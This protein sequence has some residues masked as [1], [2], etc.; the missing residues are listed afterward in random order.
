[1]AKKMR[2]ALTEEEKKHLAYLRK[3]GILI[4]LIVLLVA[5]V[6]IEVILL[7]QELVEIAG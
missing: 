6:T 7:L 2:P 1:M 4:I 5:M 3:K